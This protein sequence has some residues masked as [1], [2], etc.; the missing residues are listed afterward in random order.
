MQWG[1]ILV[2]L[3][4]QNYAYNIIISQFSRYNKDK[5]TNKTICAMIK[6]NIFRLMA[7]LMVATL[8]TGFASCGD[9]D[10]DNGISSPIV[11][12][13][14]STKNANETFTFQSNGKCRRLYQAPAVKG[15][16][17]LVV[18]DD[19]VEQYFDGTYTVTDDNSLTVTWNTK[20]T[21]KV[22]SNGKQETKTEKFDPVRVETGY[23]TLNG[24]SIEINLG[25]GTAYSTWRGTS[26]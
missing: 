1:Y 3:C 4:C 26:K 15:V 16:T 8:C 6:K 12:T 7:I 21:T 9:D 14:V 10:D 17:D 25:D 18:D 19:V 22:D 2:V 20:T 13:W 11:N 24:N 23:F 5:Q